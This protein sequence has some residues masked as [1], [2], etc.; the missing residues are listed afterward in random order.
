[1]AAQTR[2]LKTLSGNVRKPAQSSRGPDLV[3]RIIGCVRTP[4]RTLEQCPRNIEPGGA[5]CELRLLD[6]YRA[7]L[8]GLQAGQPIL[9]LYWLDQAERSAAPQSGRAGDSGKGVFALRSP[10]R[11]NPIA[12]AVVE[13]ESIGPGWV[14]VRGM[15]CVDGTPLL[16]IKP[17]M[18]RA[19]ALS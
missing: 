10:H 19:P 7:G 11:P 13:V 14:R 2:G 5:V 6:E 4:Y 15:D 16:D 9:V 1:V 18:S 3:L 8:S 17:A 12:A